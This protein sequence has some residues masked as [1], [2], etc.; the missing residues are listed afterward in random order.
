[1][2]VHPFFDDIA[3]AVL[4]GEAIKRAALRNGLSLGRLER[5]LNN[6]CRRANPVAFRTLQ[7]GRYIVDLPVS[8]LRKHKGSFLPARPASEKIGKS[9]SIWCLRGV[10]GITLT[11]IYQAGINT[12]EE[13]TTTP[14]KAL[15]KLPKVGA[16]GLARIGQ[17]LRSQGLAEQ[18]N[19]RDTEDAPCP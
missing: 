11:G 9:S 14:V 12:I 2:E 13:L 16:E 4:S 19:A 10:P 1:M 8:I 15:F 17:A 18:A 6:Y 7:P 5:I 3:I